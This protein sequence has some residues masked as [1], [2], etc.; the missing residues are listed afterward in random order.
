MIAGW[1]WLKSFLIFFGLLVTAGAVDVL[2]GR[3]CAPGDSL[4]WPH[5]PL[6][7]PAVTDCAVAVP[8]GNTA[9]KDAHNRTTVKV[10][11]SFRSQAEFLQPPEVEEELLL[12]L[13]HTVCVGGRFQIVSYLRFALLKSPATNLA[14]GYVAYSLHKV[15]CSSL[16]AV[17]A[18]ACEVF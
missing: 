13:H 8:D 12:L 15:Q 17:V 2:E 18:F 14:S 5:Q 4:G 16:R 9:R 1:K 11:D 7:S 6:E 10:C 3:Q